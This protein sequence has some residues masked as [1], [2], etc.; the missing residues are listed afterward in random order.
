MLYGFYFILSFHFIVENKKTPPT[1][2]WYCNIC[3]IILIFGW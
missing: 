2:L 3:V 1:L